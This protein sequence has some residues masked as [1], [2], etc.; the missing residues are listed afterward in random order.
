MECIASFAYQSSRAF[1]C[2]KVLQPKSLELKKHRAIFEQRLKKK[3]KKRINKGVI[4][5]NIVFNVTNSNPIYREYFGVGE[6]DSPIFDLSLI[7]SLIVF[8]EEI[9]R[10][11]SKIMGRNQTSPSSHPIRKRQENR[12]ELKF[13]YSLL[14]L[15]CEAIH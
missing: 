3:K 12:P 11:P 1:G 2:D 6:I 9:S 8:N 5:S 15:V 14:G 7:R 10:H 13:Q 4:C